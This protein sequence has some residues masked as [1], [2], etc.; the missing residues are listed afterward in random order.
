MVIIS[1]FFRAQDGVYGHHKVASFPQY[2]QKPA[3]NVN[4][5]QKPSL[6]ALIRDPKA[7]TLLILLVCLDLECI[8]VLNVKFLID[9][10]MALPK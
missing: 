8:C 10:K 7:V 6:S 3:K 5:S 1:M 2:W 4:N 9:V